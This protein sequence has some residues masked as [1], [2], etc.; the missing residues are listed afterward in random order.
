MK[1]IRASGSLSRAPIDIYYIRILEM[2]RDYNISMK[3]AIEW[4]F[5]GFMPCPQRGVILT[6][7]EEIEF[8]LFINY[9]PKKDS[10]IFQGIALGYMPDYELI[11]EETAKQENKGSP[12]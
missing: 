6:P 7:E 4:D 12:T 10:R 8:Y 3:E 1:H 2:M 11:N 5:D 9:I